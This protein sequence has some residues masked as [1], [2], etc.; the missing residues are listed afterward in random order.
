MPSPETYDAIILGAGQAALPLAHKLAA[1]GRRTALIE[2]HWVGGTCINTGCTPTKTMIASAQ[3]ANLAR[4]AGD[5]GVQVGQVQVDLPVIVNRKRQ[6][7]ESFRRPNEQRLEA[8]DGIDLIYGQAYFNGERQLTV[9][10]RQ[11]D[12]RS[13]Q[14]ETI[15]INTGGRP[16]PP[17]PPGL[18]RLKAL[19]SSAMLELTELPSHLIV[20]GGGYVGVEFGQMFRRF[21]AEVTIVQRAAQLLPFEDEDIA[22]T[23]QDI[24]AEEG[25]DLHLGS[26]AT[27]AG[28]SDHGGIFL[29]VEAGGRTQRLE[30]SHLLVA[31]GRQPN[32]EAI[33]AE[34]AGVELDERGYIQVDNRLR[35]TAA[36][37]FAVGDVKGGPAFTH[38]SY[39][40]HRIVADQLLGDGSATTEGRMV[41]YT[42]FTQPQLGRIGLTESQARQ[43]GQSIGVAEL[44]MSH[45]ARA[46][47]LG[48][49]RGKMKAVV[50][51]QTQQILGAAIL[52]MEGG[53]LMGALQ[54]A[55]M[56]GLP[57]PR[58]QEATFAHP[59]LMEAFNNL[60][61]A[62]N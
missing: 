28:Q 62:V 49:T 11:G 36:G 1:A 59:T 27:E 37:I 33:R 44:P 61:S 52:G 29:M 12:Q 43:S 57:Y 16:Q 45:V 19:D 50:D 21:G 24:L 18:E 6:I 34:A 5:F 14:A 58:L 31:T 2:R 17:A 30:G 13:L 53:E 56:A 26:M 7:V 47:E 40:D 10:T 23:L 46:I 42:V 48:D 22:E 15:I 41:P 9:E 25:V 39:D 38:I 35:T 4:R 54:V 55:M 20:L 3:V 51:R 32:T 8:A 60:F